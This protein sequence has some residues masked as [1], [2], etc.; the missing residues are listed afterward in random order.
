MR[1]GR[2]GIVGRIPSSADEISLSWTT[3]LIELGVACGRPHVRH[4]LQYGSLGAFVPGKAAAQR[5]GFTAVGVQDW[6]LKERF[7]WQVA[8]VGSFQ[9][10]Q[11]PMSVPEPGWLRAI[12]TVNAQVKA[13]TAEPETAEDVDDVSRLTSRCKWSLGEMFGQHVKH[14]WALL[15]IQVFLH[16]GSP[17][18]R[19]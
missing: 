12:V 19:P 2:I 4:H 6:P 9:I 7:F 17:Y 18:Y 14:P 11:R 15:L 5:H 16:E 3:L 13:E 10:E 8:G 1:I